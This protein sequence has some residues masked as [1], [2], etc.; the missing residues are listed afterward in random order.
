MGQES[1]IVHEVKGGI[2]LLFLEYL[3][4]DVCKADGSNAQHTVEAMH[5][6][7]THAFQLYQHCTSRPGER[8]C[9]HCVIGRGPLAGYHAAC[10]RRTQTGG[11]SS[12]VTQ[13]FDLHL[14]HLR[15]IM[16][17]N[18]TQAEDVAFKQLLKVSRCFLLL[19][20]SHPL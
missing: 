13:I 16:A 14:M 12:H 18:L 9:Q 15:T 1:V 17:V 11:Y 4:D 19:L 5:A 20:L 2:K 6:L 3:G 8:S 10:H 7:L